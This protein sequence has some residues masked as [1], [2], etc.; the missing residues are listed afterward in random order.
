MVLSHRKSCNFPAAN[1]LAFFKKR[2][3]F[4]K[5]HHDWVLFL[6]L[7]LNMSSYL[8]EYGYYFYFL[9]KA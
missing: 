2:I 9:Q 3:H 8:C 7:A 1:A 4:P 5:N 6:L